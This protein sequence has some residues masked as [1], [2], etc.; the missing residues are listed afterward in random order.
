MNSEIVELS[1]ELY[2]RY[3][4]SLIELLCDAVEWRHDQLLRANECSSGGGRA[5]RC[6]DFYKPIIE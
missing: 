6:H 5:K 2:V 4:A 1:R 3:R